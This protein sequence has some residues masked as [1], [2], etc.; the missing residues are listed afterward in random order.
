MMDYQPHP[1][2]A[3]FPL[4]SAD[5]RQELVNDMRAHGQREPICLHDG[6]ILDGR[7]RYAACQALGIEPRTRVYDGPSDNLSLL[8]YV[9]SL[10]ATR[11]HLTAGQ[12]AAIGLEVE[13]IFAAEAKERQR[14]S[15]RFDGRNEDGEP[16]VKADLQVVP[17]LAQPEGL[18]NV[19]PKA[20][21]QA[22][23]ALNTSHGYISDAK[24]LAEEAPE[25]L[26]QVKLGA[27]SLPPRPHLASIPHIG[28]AN[29]TCKNTGGRGALVFLRVG[30]GNARNTGRM[31]DRRPRKSAKDNTTYHHK[32]TSK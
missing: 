32:T 16:K 19:A 17:I 29:G 2:A 27:L 3:I 22:A 24:K 13:A 1:H 9:L 20:R 25:L 30:W 23:K 5:E 12:R 31:D 8:N 15:G 10:N 6:L 21:D 11:R 4:M 7:N 18:P 14:A 28:D 26:E